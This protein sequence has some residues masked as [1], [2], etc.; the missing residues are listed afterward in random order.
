MIWLLLVGLVYAQTCPF[1]RYDRGFLG[2]FSSPNFE[3]FAITPDGEYLASSTFGPV[4]VFKRNLNTWVML[5][6]A[7]GPSYNAV[8]F[9]GASPFALDI[10]H[11]GKRVAVSIMDQCNVFEWNGLAWIQLGQPIN[12]AI[13]EG[14]Y[15]Y[16]WIDLDST[17]NR[18]VLR[19]LT[20]VETYDLVGQT[21]VFVASVTTN[22]LSNSNN[23]Y[24][25]SNDGLTLYNGFDNALQ[26]FQ[27]VNGGWSLYNTIPGPV[28]R[29]SISN[30]YIAIA[31]GGSTQIY[32]KNGTFF[33][34]ISKGANSYF[35]MNDR[36]LTTSSNNDT[37]A[38]VNV[39]KFDTSIVEVSKL[40]PS[41]SNSCTGLQFGSYREFG[42]FTAIDSFDRVFIRDTYEVNSNT[43]CG[44]VRVF[45][46]CADQNEC[47]VD[48]CDINGQC[49]NQPVCQNCVVN[50]RYYAATPAKF[51]AATPRT[52]DNWICNE[53]L[54]KKVLIGPIYYMS[55]N[56]GTSGFKAGTNAWLQA[57]QRY[58]AALSDFFNS[59][60][61]LCTTCGQTQRVDYWKSSAI[62]D[63]MNF[64][65][66]SLQTAYPASTRNPF[67]SCKTG[68][69]FGRTVNL[70][71]VNE[72][73][74]LVGQF[75]D[76]NA[77]LPNCSFALLGVSSELESDEHDL[78]LEEELSITQLVFV[79]IGSVSLLAVAIFIGMKVYKQSPSG[80]Q[81]TQSMFHSRVAEDVR[82]TIPLKNMFRF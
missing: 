2:N 38:E 41:R 48:S 56:A 22:L 1:Q 62:E 3:Q 63:C 67:P 37:Y 54:V 4:T 26:I 12:V 76:G 74:T 21:W 18:M 59:E 8:K 30:T 66:V 50:H 34:T 61:N 16:P 10:S 49:Q 32:Y 64:L 36:F 55:L 58:E 79:I 72:C 60:T 24:K 17:G 6:S 25:L 35:G 69:S 39:F 70:T 47:T 68:P 53:A 33:K 81:N 52:Y 75:V 19:N 80:N 15:I 57:Y 45:S 29:W 73:V 40:F 43:G 13:S 46:P 77:A 65:R 11:D 14:N 31:G 27:F 42:V 44:N 7:F 51:Y 28:N 5:G 71:R 23:Q 20:T 78:T 82:S 9:T